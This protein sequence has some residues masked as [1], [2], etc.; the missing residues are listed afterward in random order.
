MANC[1]SYE[2]VSE[3]GVETS[4]GFDVDFF[5]GRSCVRRQR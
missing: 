3:G 4:C 5:A 2:G 1:Y